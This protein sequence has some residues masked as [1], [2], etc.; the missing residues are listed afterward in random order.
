MAKKKKDPIPRILRDYH[1][2]GH[3]V[4]AVVLGRRPK[5][6]T[7]IPKDGNLGS[8]EAGRGVTDDS[9]YNW[10]PKT[11]QSHIIELYA[12]Q[13]AEKKAGKQLGLEKF[14]DIDRWGT[15]NRDAL[16]YAAKCPELV[17]LNDPTLMAERLVER[18]WRK[19]ARVAKRLFK[20]RRIERDELLQLCGHRTGRKR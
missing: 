14:C 7:D 13:A 15:D 6:V 20:K 10:K 1:E 11:T 12:G 18:H 3:A 16:D 17:L 5:L 2:A 9:C 8:V 19:I 4:A